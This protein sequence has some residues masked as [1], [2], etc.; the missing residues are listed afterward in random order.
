MWWEDSCSWGA[1]PGEEVRTAD[2]RLGPLPVGSGEPW[3]AW[4][5]RCEWQRGFQEAGGGH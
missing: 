2:W 3:V 1:G 4:K 5:Q